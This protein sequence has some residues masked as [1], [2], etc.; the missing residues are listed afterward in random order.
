MNFSFVYLNLLSSNFNSFISLSLFKYNDI[1]LLFLIL[2]AFI[3]WLVVI[4]TCNNFDLKGIFTK[5]PYGSKFLPVLI[6]NNHVINNNDISN[7]KTISLYLNND[8]ITKTIKLDKNRL[9]YTDEQLDV[10]IIE[11][12]ENEDNLN[13]KYLEL[14]DEI[15]TLNYNKFK[16]I[17]IFIGIDALI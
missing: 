8:K 9:I 3:I 10:T 4:N 12:K 5:I 13:N 17:T 7:K 2:S 1:L 15:I 14:D 6:T 11:I 16:L